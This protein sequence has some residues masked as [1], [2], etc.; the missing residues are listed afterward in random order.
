M[1]D[2]IT[3]DAEHIPSTPALPIVVSSVA[4]ALLV[5]ALLVP[6][7]FVTGAMPEVPTMMAFVAAAPPPA[8]PPPPPP[9]PAAARPTTPRETRPVTTSAPAAPVEAP[10]S[11]EPEA[12][13]AAIDE[14]VPGGVEGGV[15]GGVLGGVVGGLP[16]DI[17]PP[18]PP[19]PPPAPRAPVRVGGQIKEP[20]LVRRIE[21][22][23]HPLAVRA[24]IQGTVILEAIVDREGR[25]A[26]VRVLRS[27]HKMLDDAAIDALRQWQYVPLVLNGVPERFVLTV[28]LSFNLTQQAAGD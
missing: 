22:V 2:L 18:P 14:G 17:P 23:Y 8:P 20:Q 7:L 21:P 26:D 24:N 5:A 6:V 19:P 9:P 13:V 16:S 4:Q 11:I 25:V 28:V 3:G 15:P 27:A 10:T 1:F 12:P